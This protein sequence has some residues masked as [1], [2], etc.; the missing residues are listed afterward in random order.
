MAQRPLVYACAEAPV[1]V[2][3]GDPSRFLP[4]DEPGCAPF[5]VSLDQGVLRTSIDRATLPAAFD[6]LDSWTVVFGLSTPEWDW[7]YSK[8]MAAAIPN[9]PGPRSGSPAP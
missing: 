4:G 8:P 2:F 3:G 9:L 5:D 6:G 1:N 7:S